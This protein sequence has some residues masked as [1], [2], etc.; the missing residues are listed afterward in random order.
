MS[1]GGEMAEMAQ[2]ISMKAEGAM[3][4]YQWRR[5]LAMKMKINN[6]YNQWRKSISAA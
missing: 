4:A 3:K 6:E 5:Q 2:S 1:K